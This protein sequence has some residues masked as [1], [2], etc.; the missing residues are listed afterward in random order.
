MASALAALP[1]F[2]SRES[3]HI[4][5]A[6]AF[7]AN[8]GGGA[9]SLRDS[10]LGVAWRAGGVTA[11]EWLLF[12]LTFLPWMALF[13]ALFV[14]VRR[15]PSH[16]ARRIQAITVVG[17]MILAAHGIWETTR[18]C[19]S[20]V[21]PP[22]LN[23][24][25][26]LVE[27]ASKSTG[28]TL[29][30]PRAAA[31]AEMFA[32]PRNEDS[33][34][35][36]PLQ[37]CLRSPLAW[38]T[39]HR[40]S[41][42]AAVVLTYPFDT[43]RPLFDLLSASKDWTPATIDAHGVLFKRT[44]S[45]QEPTSKESAAPHFASPREQAL[46]LARNALVLD[47][48]GRHAQSLTFM[49]KALSLQPQNPPVLAL[50]ASLSAAHGKWHRAKSE[51][52]SALAADASSVPARY[53]L[54]LA[55]MKTGALDQALSESSTLVALAPNDTSSLLLRA[56]I[57]EAAKDHATE[58]ASL[59]RLL[60]VAKKQNQPTDGIHILLGQAWARAGFPNQ[61]LENHRAALDGDLS[62]DQ[63]R[64]VEE[65]IEVIESHAPTSK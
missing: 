19:R 23:G 9:A 27:E 40:K 48:A 57:A 21:R 55:C 10:M 45:T 58:A 25:L 51:A 63:R 30:D 17:A 1:A 53:V 29:L 64:L 20:D 42:F 8:D 39:E 15:L 41:P 46:W 13:T 50:A 37:E 60:A 43:S 6:R 5:V 22:A 65:A 33:P 52:E 14:A 26:L 36:K 49:D 62:P 3:I 38:R 2:F 56:R 44:T 35:G 34:L 16:I 4:Q 18:A 31:F 7:E 11:T 24:P 47:A 59:E 54:A 61:A 32:I 12:C 28:R